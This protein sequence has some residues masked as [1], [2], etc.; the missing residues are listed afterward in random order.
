MSFPLP[1]KYKAEVVSRDCDHE[2]LTQPKGYEP[3]QQIT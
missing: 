1:D 3:L 2:F